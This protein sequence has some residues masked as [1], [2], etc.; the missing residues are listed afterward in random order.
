MYQSLKEDI[1]KDSSIEHL[2]T[3]K[4]DYLVSIY[5]NKKGKKS[6]YLITG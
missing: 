3:S 1:D 4:G 5:Q 2:I 6:R